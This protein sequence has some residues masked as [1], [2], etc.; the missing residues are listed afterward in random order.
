MQPRDEH[1]GGEDV[2]QRDGD[3]VLEQ[4]VLHRH[5]GAAQHAVR[6]EKHIRDGVFEPQGD[7]GGDWPEDGENFTRHRG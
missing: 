6:D 7:E 1:G 3:D 5:R 4:H 2:P